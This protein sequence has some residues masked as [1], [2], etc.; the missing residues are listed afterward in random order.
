VVIV[1]MPVVVVPMML[2]MMTV[3]VGH[4][5]YLAQSVVETFADQLHLVFVQGDE[6]PDQV[7]DQQCPTHP[8]PHNRGVEAK[9]L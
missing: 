1:V 8:N 5:V 4:D 2:V 6:T 7:G 3:I 9:R